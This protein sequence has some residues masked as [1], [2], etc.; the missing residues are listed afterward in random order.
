MDGGFIPF[1]T[2]CMAYPLM[3]T[4]TI[5]DTMYEVETLTLGE[6]TAFGLLPDLRDRS[7]YYRKANTA[8]LILKRFI[9]K[10]LL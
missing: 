9:I 5:M 4:L 3:L 10:L 7:F 8:S 6:I 2:C 1:E